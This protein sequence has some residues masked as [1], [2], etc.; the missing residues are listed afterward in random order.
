MTPTPN[1]A[2]VLKKLFSCVFL[3][4]TVRWGIADNIEKYSDEQCSSMSESLDRLLRHQTKLIASCATRSPEKAEQILQSLQTFQRESRMQCNRTREDKDS[5]SDRDKL[6][7]IE[8]GF[9]LP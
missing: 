5:S 6:T 9:A 1:Q 2:T 4:S 3:E 8:S 7:S